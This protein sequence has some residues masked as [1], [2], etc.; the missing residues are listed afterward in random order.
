[1]G[2]AEAPP[3]WDGG[4][5]D[6]KKYSPPSHVLPCRTWSRALGPTP[7]RWGGGAWLTL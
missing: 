5:A 2:S 6:H 7:L 3:L 4:V 1:M